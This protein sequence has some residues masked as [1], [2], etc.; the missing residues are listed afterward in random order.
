MTPH[1]FSPTGRLV[2]QAVFPRLEPIVKEPIALQVDYAKME[3]LLIEHLLNE[4]PDNVKLVYT[5]HDT[6]GFEVAYGPK[7]V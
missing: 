5:M 7:D 3:K 1:D 6:Y 4:L 2:T